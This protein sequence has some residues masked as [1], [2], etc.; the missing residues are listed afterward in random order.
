MIQDI[1]ITPIQKVLHERQKLQK[2]FCSFHTEVSMIKYRAFSQVIDSGS[3]RKAAEV[4]GYSQPGLSHILNSFEDELGFPLMIRGNSG[5]RPTENGKKILIYCRQMIEIENNMKQLASSINEI[6]SGSISIGAPNSMLVG[7]IPS[8][9]KDFSELYPDIKLLIKEYNLCDIE[10]E[11]QNGF[12]D[13]GFFTDEYSGE[14]QFYPLF[15]DSIC[16]VMHKNHPLADLEKIPASVLAHEELIMQVQNWNDIANIV[17]RN[18][19]FSSSP[20]YHCASDAAGFSLVGNNMGVYIISKLQEKSMPP[21]VVIREFE[22]DFT[23]TIG[24]GI[25]SLKKASPLQK[26]FIKLAQQKLQSL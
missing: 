25:K 4:L 7:F 15:E 20:K 11:L 6:T 12:I 9:L 16:L 23:R 19:D 22:E 26:A 5:I 14:C 1:T 2:F 8:L 21:N 24:I 17:L 13:I 3:I 18:V 10:Q